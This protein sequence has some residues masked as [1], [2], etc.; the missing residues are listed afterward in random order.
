M[1][2][3]Q[4]ASCQGCEKCTVGYD[5]ARGSHDPRYRWRNGYRVNFDLFS[6]GEYAGPAR[7]PHLSEY[8]VRPGDVLQFTY[9]VSRDVVG[10][11]YRIGVGD[12]LMVESRFDEKLNRGTLAS[13]IEVQPDGTITV[14]LL[15]PVHAAGLT[16]D[17][18][19]KMLD[20]KYS[21]YY[22]KT[23]ID[24]TPVKTNVANEDIR[25]AVAGAGGFSEQ[26]VTRT[27][28]PDGRITLPRVGE[29]WVH[30][31]TI[32]EVKREVNLHYRTFVTGLEVEPALATQAPH[33]VAVLGEVNQAGRFEMTGPT[34]VLS[35]IALAQGHRVGANLRQVVVFRRADDW[36]LVSTV[37]DVR[38]AV[39]GKD[40][41][42][43]DEIW[44]RD[45]DVV[46][47]PA[48]PIQRFDNFVSLVFTQGIY[49]VIPFQGFDLVEAVN[50]FTVD[51]NN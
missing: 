46:I 44:L 43:A 29:I 48:S 26:A 51:N 31:L 41:L 47:V 18:L 12:Q 6:Q 16:F 27:V 17:Q 20:E 24:V 35:A 13:G 25:V 38:Q 22:K 45:G 21:Q 30:G 5:S 33:L 11:T 28:T 34:T 10:E 23:G 39:I 7:A 8:R 14:S 3:G 15:G 1:V 42:P 37:L 4:C 40:P 19:K 49:G 9:V 36:R 2:V 50:G 32:G